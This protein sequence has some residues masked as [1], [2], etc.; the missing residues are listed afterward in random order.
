MTNPITAS[1]NS[2]QPGASNNDSKISLVANPTKNTNTINS[3]RSLRGDSKKPTGSSLLDR[4]DATLTTCAKAINEQPIKSLQAKAGRTVGIPGLILKGISVADQIGA[5]VSFVASKILGLVFKDYARTLVCAPIRAVVTLVIL[6]IEAGVGAVAGVIAGICIGL[7]KLGQ[8]LGKLGQLIYNKILAPIGRAIK[9]VVCAIGRAICAIGRAIK[10]V[11]INI[12]KGACFIGRGV[13]DALVGIR[14]TL[15][16]LKD[17]L[18]TIKELK[19][20]VNTLKEQ[21]NQLRNQV[22][23]TD[24]IVAQSEQSKEEISVVSSSSTLNVD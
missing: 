9:T 8:L 23:A 2:S 12:A 19:E 6:L 16:D 11:T 24:R 10:F 17:A 5:K 4:I 21:I 13:R 22:P 20:E 7:Y 3:Q 1:V 15:Q 18:K 14:T